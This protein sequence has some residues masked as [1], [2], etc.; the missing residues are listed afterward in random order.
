MAK[1]T[2]REIYLDLH[3]HRLVS[4]KDIYADGRWIN[5]VHYLFQHPCFDWDGFYPV[6]RREDGKVVNII[7]ADCVPEGVKWFD[8]Q[9]NYTDNE[10]WQFAID[11]DSL[12]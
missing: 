9:L 7:P 4:I 3:N 8:N 11:A 5:Y 10:H 2:D 6:V 12:Q 1:R